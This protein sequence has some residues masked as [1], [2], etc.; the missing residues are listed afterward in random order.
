MAKVI[1]FAP[2]AEEPDIYEMDKQQLQ[3]YLSVLEEELVKLDAREPRSQK[4]EAYEVWADEHE[5]LEDYMDEV[6][7]LLEEL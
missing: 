1:D 7:E 3:A 2:M 6:R 5:E 4:S